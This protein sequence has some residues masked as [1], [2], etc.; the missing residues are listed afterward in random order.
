[1]K[2]IFSLVLAGIVG[3]LITLG[4][5]QYLQESPTS[6]DHQPT[7]AQTVKNVN[8]PA[9]TTK[10]SVSV[11]F[12][13]A[14]A[15]SMPAV[16]HISSIIEQPTSGESDPF[17]FFFGDGFQSPFGDGMP[18]GGTGSGVIYTEDGYIITNNHVVAGATE[19]EVTLYDNRTF[20]AKVVGTDEKSDLAVIK[21]E[22]YGFPTL[23]LAD[24]DDAE[25]G[26]W[27]LA[28]GNPFD[29]TS[30][31]TAGIISAKGRNINLL[32]GGKAIESFI[33]T[34]AA[35]NPG[36]SGGALVDIEGKLLG[37][38]TAIASRTGSFAG[39]SFAIPAGLVKRVVSDIIQFGDYQ[40]PFLGVT[41]S[42]LDGSYAQELG[43]D[44]TQGVVI[45]NLVEGG[46]AEQAGLQP[47]DVIVGIDG[48]EVKSVPE[49]QERIGRA[50]VGDLI[51]LNINRSGRD[52]AIS[53]ELRSE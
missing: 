12:R 47:K 38:N 51:T 42:E 32:G 15:K 17:R 50:Q 3:G 28:V 4:G 2:Q 27:V 16:V 14:A 5:F 29:L 22:G 30:T 18:R 24:S 13:D 9:L 35:V 48:N 26:E 40:R 31:V 45:E 44:I 8:I 21:I 52:R 7:Y 43:I 53:V 39:Y 11:D 34:D 46:S 49:L 6:N 20:K 33:Q 37:I 1:M 41:I 19:L 36:N 25:I 23:E 10:N